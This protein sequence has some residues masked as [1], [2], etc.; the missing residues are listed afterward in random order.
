[1]NNPE[2]LSTYSGADRSEELCD[3]KDIITCEVCGWGLHKGAAS[4]HVL[5]SAITKISEH[6]DAV[7]DCE[8]HKLKSVGT[9]SPIS[10]WAKS[11]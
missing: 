5:R 4:E 8:L 1:M 6:V 3:A 11:V 9:V 7:H 10:P 2:K